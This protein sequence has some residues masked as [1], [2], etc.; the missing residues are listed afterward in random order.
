MVQIFAPQ[1]FMTC[2][3]L[4]NR[5]NLPDLRCNLVGG[6]NFYVYSFKTMKLNPDVHIPSSVFNY[7]SFF[8]SLYSGDHQ[9]KNSVFSV[10]LLVITFFDVAL[11]LMNV[12]ADNLKGPITAFLVNCQLIQ[13][14][15][16]GLNV[17]LPLK[18]LSCSC[19]VYKLMHLETKRNN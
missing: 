14:L 4:Q 11:S 18:A 1:L 13:L 6:S 9:K 17:I 7:L 12:E 3:C 15:I 10:F 8:L 2:R 19:S 5:E 16:L